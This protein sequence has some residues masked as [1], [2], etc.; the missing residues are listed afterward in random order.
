MSKRIEILRLFYDDIDEDSRLN[1]SRQGQLEYLTTMNYIHC[2][3]KAGAKILEIGAG[4]GR[5]SI[6]LAKEGYNVTAVELVE[7]NLEVLKNNSTGIEN[8]ISYQ[9]DALNEAIYI[10]P[11]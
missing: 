10:L 7:S 11:F 3:A 8:I 6:A 1:I 9:G 4:T 5:Y 2:Y